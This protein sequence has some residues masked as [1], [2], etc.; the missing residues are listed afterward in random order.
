MTRSSFPALYGQS[1]VLARELA[2]ARE[3]AQELLRLA[4]GAMPPR[5]WWG[6]VSSGPSCS[7]W[8]LAEG[9]SPT[10]RGARP[11]RSRAGPELAL[12]LRHRLARGLLP[13]ALPSAPCPRLPGAGPGAAERG[14]RPPPGS[15]LIPARPLKPSSTIRPSISSSTN[16][17]RPRAAE[18]LIALATEQASRS[19][20]RRAWSSGDGRWQPTG[21][22]RTA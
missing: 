21:A 9:A 12:R 14:A 13:L 4:E 2:A 16:G 20:W 3:A 1:V 8:R 18:A 22:R 5:R 10:Q 19:G 11:L 6:I 7:S 17:K 15:W